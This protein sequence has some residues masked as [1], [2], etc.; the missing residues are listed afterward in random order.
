MRSFLLKGWPQ[1]P[2]HECVAV[3]PLPSWL[4][5][6]TREWVVLSMLQCAP[7]ETRIS[8]PKASNNSFSEKQDGNLRELVYMPGWEMRCLSQ[9][10]NFGFTESPLLLATLLLWVWWSLCIGKRFGSCGI[11]LRRVSSVC[12]ASP[13]LQASRTQTGFSSM[14]CNGHPLSLIAGWPT[15][16]CSLLLMLTFQVLGRLAGLVATRQNS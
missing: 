4:N 13:C 6:I 12:S 2:E 11:L 15:R 9:K 3:F 8:K 1:C 16:R 5:P 7:K 14:D 10:L